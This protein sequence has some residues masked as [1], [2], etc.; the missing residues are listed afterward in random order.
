MVEIVN[1]GLLIGLI[2]SSMISI[3]M[4]F[5]FFLTKI[6]Q[7]AWGRWRRKQMH[8][9]GG[10]VN[11]LLVT[12]DGVLKEVFTKVTEGKFKHKDFSYTRVPRLSLNFKGIPSYIHKEGVP[13]PVDV[14]DLDDGLL[15]S[16]ELDQ[17]MNAQSSFD[18][19]L[20]LEKATPF[21]LFGAL[22]LIGAFAA[23]A[24]F[25]YMSYEMLRD[26]TFEAVKIAASPVSSALGA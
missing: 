14:W 12:K 19:K 4:I 18:F 10:Y 9:K 22:I 2:F 3:F 24:F 7:D 23:M 5:F 15:S 25:N 26:G 8:K 1:Q 17:V 6:G 21:L 16:Q 11:T 13:V 20:W